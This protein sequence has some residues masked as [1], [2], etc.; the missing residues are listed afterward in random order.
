[1]GRRAALAAAAVSIMFVTGIA[2]GASTWGG[3]PVN[4]TPPSISGTAQV[5]MTL[6]ARYGKWR[7]RNLKYAYAWLRCDSTG[8][9][10]SALGAAR[11]TYVLVSS[12][13][14]G[15][16]RVAVTASSPSGSTVA[17]SAATSPVLTTTPP[18]TVATMPANTAP[19]TISGSAQQG[20]TLTATT[21]S[22][23][24]STPL[25]YAYQWQRCDSSGASCAPLPVTGTT[26]VLASTDVGST[27][28]VSV[29]ADNTA[30]SATATSAPTAA[31]AAL[32]AS[33]P[34]PAPGGTV[35]C[36]GD[37][38]YG[39]QGNYTQNGWARQFP[40]GHPERVSFD[41][42]VSV[43]QSLGCHTVRAE[44]RSGD[45]DT[46]GGTVNLRAQTYKDPS[47]T[48]YDTMGTNRG[49]TTW[50]GFA[51]S[52]NAGYVPQSDPN[53][54]NWTTNGIVD[55]YIIRFKCFCSY[56]AQVICEEMEVECRS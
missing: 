37:P 45:L 2:S 9:S 43:M 13:A 46:K 31:V 25:N 21:G 52:T 34:T 24:G 54:P 20:Q 50:Y 22:W 15:T 11:S 12:D 3:A 4:V 41:D 39:Y 28:R 55:G 47:Q 30:G 7:G 27:I 35:F 6:T 19:P 10:C 44:L 29:T 17:T 14:G 5:G 40:L 56:R 1:M 32:P 53:N 23:G 48:L 49:Q 38:A 26:D 16:M 42:S 8:G 36:F 18:T 33:A 51:F